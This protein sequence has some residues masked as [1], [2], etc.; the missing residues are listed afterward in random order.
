[1]IRVLLLDSPTRLRVEPAEAVVSLPGDQVATS[2]MMQMMTSTVKYS[3][4]LTSDTE[5]PSFRS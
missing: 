2:R 1:M 3:S 5:E 4:T